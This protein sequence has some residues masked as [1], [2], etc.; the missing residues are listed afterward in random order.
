MNNK[1][2]PTQKYL[3]L[4]EYYK[5]MHREGANSQTPENTYN[6][7][8]T[9]VFADFIKKIIEKNECKT[10][11]DYGSGKGDRYFNESVFLNKKYP[12][13]KSFWNIETTLFDP[14][15]PYPKPTNKKFDIVISIDVLEHI[16]VNDLSWVIK[17]IFNFSNK[18]VFFNIACHPANAKLPDGNNAHVSVY[19]P[20][21]WAGFIS[22]IAID[23]NA[24]FLLV[25][26]YREK[27]KVND[28]YFNYGFNDKFE[29]YKS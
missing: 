19:P 2:S 12:P 18:I 13:L 5:R 4:V 3:D 6:G 8:S 29:N 11:L 28:Q 17:E 15:V 27:N 26:T 9:M 14:G 16:P 24:K 22:S 20:L 1:I 21:W 7:Y 23:L 25:C 10:L